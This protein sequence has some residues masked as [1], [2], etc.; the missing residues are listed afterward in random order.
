MW[1]TVTL[2]A[3][4]VVTTCGGIVERGSMHDAMLVGLKTYRTVRRVTVDQPQK[5]TI[6]CHLG[7]NCPKCE[8]HMTADII[9]DYAVDKTL[10][11]MRSVNCSQYTAR[12][13]SGTFPCVFNRD[14]L[15]TTCNG[16][17]PLGTENATWR[18]G[19]THVNPINTILPQRPVPSRGNVT[20]TPFKAEPTLLSLAGLGLAKLIQMSAAYSGT[21][22]ITTSVYGKQWDLNFDS[23]DAM[24]ELDTKLAL[25]ETGPRSL[26]VSWTAWLEDT[27]LIVNLLSTWNIDQSTNGYNEY[28][29]YSSQPDERT[30][31]S[32]RSLSRVKQTTTEVN[33]GLYD[34]VPD[35]PPPAANWSTL[36]SH[37]TVSYSRTDIESPRIVVGGKP[38]VIQYVAALKTSSLEPRLCPAIT[39]VSACDIMRN[40]A[41]DERQLRNIGNVTAFYLRDLNVHKGHKYICTTGNVIGTKGLRVAV[42]YKSPAM[43]SE[44]PAWMELPIKHLSRC[45]GRVYN[46][47]NCE[48]TQQL[49]HLIGPPRKTN[50]GTVHKF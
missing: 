41:L 24:F 25:P 38:S 14:G 6:T 30:N 37:T 23:Q 1:K 20:A 10:I 5:V 21:G 29:Y 16:P 42:E 28:D 26:E 33:G 46:V 18:F 39:V 7:S 19:Y 40:I 35:N 34:Q 2:I 31:I 13:W 17:L 43:Y 47:S 12:D 8:W 9:G 36:T 32:E 48:N 3:L 22:V 27:R 45:A 50:R 4:A 44:H 49:A 15:T 11:Y